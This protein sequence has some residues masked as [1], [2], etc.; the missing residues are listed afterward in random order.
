MSGG[1]IKYEILMNMQRNIF[2]KDLSQLYK[3]LSEKTFAIQHP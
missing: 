3:E 1:E 2:C